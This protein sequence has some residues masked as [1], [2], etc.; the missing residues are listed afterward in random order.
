MAEDTTASPKSLYESMS[1]LELFP[2][3]FPVLINRFADPSLRANTSIATKMKMVDIIPT[4]FILNFKN[5]SG[6][7][8][9]TGS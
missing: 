7:G 3:G 8:Q 4:G 2:V 6:T 5:L 9:T 1:Q